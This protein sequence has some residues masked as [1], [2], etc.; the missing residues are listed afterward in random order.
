MRVVEKACRGNVNPKDLDDILSMG[1]RLSARI[2][3]AAL[4]SLGVKSRYFDIVED[5]R[6]TQ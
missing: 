3:S 5:Q 6:K 1:E 2:F 4:K